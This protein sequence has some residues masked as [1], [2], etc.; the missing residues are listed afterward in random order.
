MATPDRKNTPFLLL[1][2]PRTGAYLG[3]RLRMQV[4]MGKTKDDNIS[5]ILLPKGVETP[6]PMKTPGYSV[7]E[8]EEDDRVHMEDCLQRF[9]VRLIDQPD[10]ILEMLSHAQYTTWDSFTM[11]DVD[12]IPGLTFP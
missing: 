12:E 7:P 10:E 6:K 9:L 1:R 3:R 11:M 4:N 2:T 8:Q 5:D